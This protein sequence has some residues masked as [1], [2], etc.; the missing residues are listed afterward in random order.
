MRHRAYKTELKVNNKERSL[1]YQYA[2]TA[3]FAYNWALT[4]KIEAFKAKSKIPNYA[5]LSKALTVLKKNEFSWMY[6]YSKCVPQSAFFDVDEAFNNFFKKCKLK[7]QGKH[8]GPPG[9]PKFKKK[10][11]KKSFRLFGVGE[12]R[13]TNNAIRLP[14]IGVLRLKQ[15]NYLPKTSKILSA[16]ISE[17]AG[18]WFV[19]IA[20]EE[21]SQPYTGSKDKHDIVGVDLGLKTL[22]TISDGT[23]IQNPKPLTKKLKKLRK[24]NK[25]LNRKKKGGKNWHKSV[26]KLGVLH[27]RISNVRQDTLNKITTTLAKTKRVVAIEDLQVSNMTKNRSLAKAI[28]DVGWFEFRRQLTYKGLLYNCQ[29]I[30]ADKFFPSSK[31]CSSCGNINKDLELPDR[32]W[33]CQNCSTHHDRDFNA[34]KNLERIAVGSTVNACGEESSDLVSYLGETFFREA[35]MRQ[36]KLFR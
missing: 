12:I 29:V 11:G 18:R 35:G 20:V 31:M 25:D 30:V 8:K 3:R 21:E 2:G 27:W 13:V 32:E 36:V 10:K 5:G 6:D 15:S 24:L 4:L 22:A 19:S 14:R 16:T 7:K 28:S 17:K 33:D 26:K 9:F 1:L 23:I 34:A